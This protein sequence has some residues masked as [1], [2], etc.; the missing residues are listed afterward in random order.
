M[1][2]NA[3][4]GIK[5]QPFV[6]PTTGINP[7][8]NILRTPDHCFD[9]LPDFPYKPNYI[10][11]QIH[12]EVRIHYIDEGPTNAKETIL[13]MHGEPTWVYLYRHMIPVLVKAGY[14]VVAVDL[15]GFGRSDKPALR[16]DYSYERQVNWITE[17]L[18]LL[19][20]KDITL[21]A[22]DWGG[23]IG[24]RVLANM[25]ERFSRVVI[26]NTGLPMG[27]NQVTELFKVWASVVS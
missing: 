7:I 24:L 9:N 15:P 22:Q 1:T 5:Q 11:T 8:K 12:S 19:K 20:L 27:G 25:P 10:T 17:W 18:V 4:K 23:L 13:L 21:F 14:R 3:F 16:E 2:E 26:S 6:I